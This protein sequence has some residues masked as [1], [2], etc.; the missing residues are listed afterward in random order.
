MADF[1]D[2]EGTPVVYIKLERINTTL[3]RTEG[4]QVESARPRKTRMDV[5]SVAYSERTDGYL[6]VRSVVQST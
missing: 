5:R 2:R 6:V 3:P 1:P 4:R